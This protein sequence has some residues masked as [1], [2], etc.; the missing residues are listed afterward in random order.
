M[1]VKLVFTFFFLL[2]FSLVI[3]FYVLVISL[4]YNP[5]YRLFSNLNVVEVKR[6]LPEGFGFFTRDPRENKM[7]FYRIENGIFHKFMDKDSKAI[8]ALYFS[9]KVRAINLEAGTIYE[10]LVGN[11]N[12][13]ECNNITRD[14]CFLDEKVPLVEIQNSTKHALI[15]GDFI[16]Q[17]YETL[18]WAWSSSFSQ[19]LMPS[20]VVRLKIA[21]NEID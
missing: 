2:V 6:L 19:E 5:A 3:I 15:C 9:R 1:K 10:S 12:W 20:N 18:P 7:V 21:C 16:V 17:I 4:P 8:E 13:Y 11:A 14:K